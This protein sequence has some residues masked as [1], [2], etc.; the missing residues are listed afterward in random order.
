VKKL[1]SLVVLVACGV[2]IG[3]EK[4]KQPVT[5]NFKTPLEIIQTVPSSMYPTDVKG[6]TALKMDAVN[7]VLKEKAKG[8]TVTLDAIVKEVK[9]VKEA[10][11]DFRLNVIGKPV[12]VGSTKVQVWYYFDEDQKA[13][14][15]GLNPDD[16]LTITGTISNPRFAKVG[17]GVPLII[18]VYHCEI[19]SS[20][21]GPKK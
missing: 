8:K 2:V 3:A 6:W 21:A 20:K 12:S 1:L 7:D 15:A 13:K 10:E 11:P 14:L 17:D 5:D 4:P 18:D 16:K 19:L 9:V